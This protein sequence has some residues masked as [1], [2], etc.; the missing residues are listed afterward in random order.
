MTVE[1]KIRVP[2]TCK[3]AHRGFTLPNGVKVIVITN[4]EA[5]KSSATVSIN[6]GTHLD[7]VELPGLA[8]LCEHM[9]FL[10][11]D[12]HPEEGLYNKVLAQNGGNSN[13]WTEDSRTMY[14]YKC[15]ND[16]FLEVLDMFLHFFICPLFTASSLEREV[17]AVHSEDEKNHSSDYWCTAELMK[18]TVANKAHPC[19][20]YGN[21]NAKTLWDD[22]RAAGVDVRARLLEFY[23]RHYV[24]ENATVA[25]YTALD[26]DAV[27]AVLE[28]VI[29]KM[30]SGERTVNAPGVAP[31]DFGRIGKGAWYNIKGNTAA[32]TLKLHFPI[33]Y[34]VRHNASKPASYASHILGHEC[35]GTVLAVLKHEGLATEMWCGAGRGID[36]DWDNFSF[37]ITLTSEG[38]KKVDAVVGIVFQAIEHLRREGV[39]AEIVEEARQTAQLGF[40]VAQIDDPTMHAAGLAGSANVFGLADCYSCHHLIEERDDA[41]SLKVI[42]CLTP[43]NCFFILQL[44][45]FDAVHDRSAAAAADA[46]EGLTLPVAAFPA[47][48]ARTTQTTLHHSAPFGSANV[49]ASFLEAWA[50]PAAVHPLLQRVKHNPYIATAFDTVALGTAQYP[51]K[52]EMP[53]GTYYH[54]LDHRFAVPRAAFVVTFQSAAAYG[55]PRNRFFTRVAASIVRLALTETLY[56]G[57][58]GSV[59]GDVAADTHGLSFT[60]EGPTHKMPEF[61]AAVLRAILSGD[62]Y[63]EDTY[64][65]Y[66]ERVLQ[67]LMSVRQQQPYLLAGERANVWLHAVRW[68]AEEVLTAA[69]GEE[70]K[71]RD[72]AAAMK[73]APAFAE[74]KQFITAEFAATMRYEAM[75]CG[76]VADAVADDAMAEVEALLAARGV[77]PCT[78]ADLPDNRTGLKIPTRAE[79]AAAVPQRTTASAAAATLPPFGALTLDRV[80]NPKDNNSAV[81]VLFQLGV[82]DP[83]TRALSD[84][85][86]AL[87]S[88]AF[89]DA[90]RTKETLGY[91]V[92]SGASVMEDVATLVFTAQSASFGVPYLLSR[93]YAFIDAMPHMLAGLDDA[94]FAKIV[95]A[96]V[97]ARQDVAKSVR[98]EA[99]KMWAR[100]TNPFGFDSREKEVAALQAMTRAELA[101]FAERAFCSGAAGARCMATCYFGDDASMAAFE[102]DVVAGA[103][104]GEGVAIALPVKATPTVGDEDVPLAEFKDL[105]DGSRPTVAFALF[106]DRAA[107]RAAADK[108]KVE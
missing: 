73:A 17:Q 42:E 5:T 32:Q 66:G 7:P 107:F 56:F 105:A 58:L 108:F 19:S 60:T 4:P 40:E 96:Q 99:T 18:L 80:P 50:K 91:V 104:H 101:A 23:Q 92:G 71:Q 26:A 21:G 8:H 79:L 63:T 103:K 3:T 82:R 86:M 20:R 67:S 106:T 14:Y 59:A 34:S 24:A 1:T 35:E 98:D 70:A 29:G 83:A 13:A 36:L 37:G 62:A 12:T 81:R 33:P 44:Q 47:S 84:C 45:D 65:I 6:T 28:P 43:G 39:V 55:T 100:R 48:A 22:P 72:P 97:A 25:V 78:R 76:N 89:F 9:L 75:W 95:A 52:K 46:A 64:K 51:S 102:A 69:V 74:F 88:S 38:V 31:Y 68:E 57:E 49:A 16:A 15:A 30:R 54:K 53:H 11:T 2:A 87:I 93:V 41:A 94:A 10:G 61:I 77:T 85:I 27:L 90:L